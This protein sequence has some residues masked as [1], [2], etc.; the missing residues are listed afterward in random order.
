MNADELESRGFMVNSKGLVL[1]NLG[2]EYRNENGEIEYLNSNIKF[3]IFCS[4]RSC[5]FGD[6]SVFNSLEEIKE[7]LISYH[8]NDWEEDIK[9]LENMSLKTILSVFEWEIHDTTEDHIILIG[10]DE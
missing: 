4:R 8:S 10:G 9:T 6:D 7:Q 3:K 1:D 5:Y 2:N